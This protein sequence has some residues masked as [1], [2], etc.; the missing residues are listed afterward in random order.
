M[1]ATTFMDVDVDVLVLDRDLLPTL[2]ATAVEGFQQ[3][4]GGAR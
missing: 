3:Q 2:T 4:R 1:M